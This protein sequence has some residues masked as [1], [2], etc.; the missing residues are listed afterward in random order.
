MPTHPFQSKQILL[1]EDNGEVR[2]TLAQALEMETYTVH[3]A[4]HGQAALLILQRITPD[5]ILSDI[6]MPHMN[7]I[8]FY[9]AVHQNPRWIAI[10]FIFLTGNDSPEDIRIGRELGVEDYLTKPVELDDLLVVISAR[11]LRAAE[12]QVA[13]VGR[14]YIET[15]NLLANTIEGR[16][17][18]THGHVERVTTYA[19]R[20][21]EGLG[22]VP[23][24]LR[25]LEF[26]AR[27]HDIG[28]IVIPDHV[29]NKPGSLTD[30]DGGQS[31]RLVPE[32]DP[33]G[34][35]PLGNPVAMQELPSP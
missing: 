1:V 14:A 13:Q 5:L 2:E 8:E 24:H 31:F 16:D 23:E 20:I 7:G 35:A 12:I 19:R 4:E 18:Y 9:K 17:A 6:N 10:P 30:E 22:W 33:N 15:V 34:H 27:L 29:L 11:L 21:A 3:Q 28:K 25:I 26:G 32:R